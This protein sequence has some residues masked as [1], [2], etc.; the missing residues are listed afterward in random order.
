MRTLVADG[1]RLYSFAHLHTVDP[2]EIKNPLEIRMFDDN[3]GESL[4]TE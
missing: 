2:S 4:V 3:I 1:L